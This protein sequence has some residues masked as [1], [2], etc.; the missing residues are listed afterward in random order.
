MKNR[1]WI[2]ISVVAL[3][4]LSTSAFQVRQNQQA[5][6]M[7]FGAPQQTVVEPGLHFKLPAPIDTVVPIDMRMHMLDPEAGEYL[8]KDKKNLLVDSFLIWS[9]SDPLKFY[10]TVGSRDGAEA[11]LD[12]IMRAVVGDVLSSYDFADILNTEHAESGLQRIAADLKAATSTRA[13]SNMGVD[14]HSAVIKRLNFPDQNKRA[15]FAR[16]ESERQA[17]S[18]GFRSEGKEEYDKIKAETDRTESEMLAEARRQAAE[19]RGNADAEAAKIYSDAYD[20]DPELYQF[21]RSLRALE[22]SLSDDSLII[23]PSDHALLNV[24]KNP[25]STGARSGASNNV[26]E[27]GN[28]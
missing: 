7:R 22:S 2:P 11:R 24:M 28:D 10:K 21:L 15:V 3:L 27:P 4:L 1:L 5:L 16:M 18:R 9:V 26:S 8:T 12:E 13:S 14:I 23:L 17:I 6:V 25:P 20:A 19:I